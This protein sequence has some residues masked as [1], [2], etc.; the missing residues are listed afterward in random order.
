MNIQSTSTQIASWK[1]AIAFLL[2][3]LM[4]W[5]QGVLL[6]Q[7]VPAGST[8]TTVVPNGSGNGVPVVNIAAPN[9][10]GLS[11][12]Q[13]NSYSVPVQGQILNNSNAATAQTQLGGVILGNPNL[14]GRSPATIILNEVVQPNRSM[15]QGYQEVAGQS[16]QVIIANPY[17]I[18]CTGCGFINA[19]RATLTTGTPNIDAAGNLTGF[20]V[21][22]GDIL[23]NGAG[24]DATGQ[25]YFDLVARSVAVQGQV[26][27]KDLLVAAGGNDFS[28]AARS[29][30]P[31]TNTGAAPAYAIDSSAL[32]G[33][34]VDRIRLMATEAGVGVRLLGD[35][36]AS[37]DDIT[38]SSAGRIELQN[39]MSA[40]RDI[41]V[42][43]VGSATPGA[44]SVGGD[45]QIYANRNLGIAG[46]AGDIALGNALV[47]AGG[48]LGLTGAAL[49]DTGGASNYRFA[50]GTL[51]V[52]VAGAASL[53]AAT[54]DASGALL[55]SGASMDLG[56]SAIFG[57]SAASGISIAATG[58]SLA[59]SGSQLSSLG[60]IVLSGTTGVSV[61]TAGFVTS[62]ADVTVTYGGAQF[63]N[64]GAFVADG[65]LQITNTQASAHIRNFGTLSAAGSMTLGSG[66]LAQFTTEDGSSTLAA[67]LTVN[68]PRIV[69]SGYL[70]ADSANFV[71]GTDLSIG[72]TGVM[73]LGTAS[74]HANALTINALSNQGMLYSAG[75]LTLATAQISN[76][77]QIVADGALAAS[78]NRAPVGPL[79]NIITNTGAIDAKDLTLTA[80]TIDLTGGT[81]Y[82][83]NDASLM[84]T[85]TLTMGGSLYAA[86]DLTLDAATISDTAAG[87]TRGAGRNFT[88]TTA[89]DLNLGA[90]QV[91]DAGKK[92]AIT[93]PN[94]N[95]A[96]GASTADTTL[97]AGGTLA[98]EGIIINTGVLTLG[99][100]NAEGSLQ[101]AGDVTLAPR[102]S[103]LSVVVNGQPGNR[104]SIQAGG[105]LSSRADSFT[106][107]GDVLANGDINL[108]PVT[109]GG[110]SSL[111]V[112]DDGWMEAGGTLSLTAGQSGARGFNTTINAGGTLAGNNFDIYNGDLSIYGGAGNIGLLQGGT[113]GGNIDVDTLNL[114][115]AYSQLRAN[116]F[117]SG[118]PALTDIRINSTAAFNNFGLLYAEQ[119]LRLWVSGDI[120]NTALG[121]IA[122]GFGDLTLRARNL[123]PGV[124][125]R[126]DNEGLIYAGR[127]LI[128]YVPED[129]TLYNKP[130]ATIGAGRDAKLGIFFDA[131]N[132]PPAY[133]STFKNEGSIDVAG[134]A[135][136]NAS[137][138]QNNIPTTIVSDSTRIGEV[139][140]AEGDSGRYITF[141]DVN[142]TPGSHDG[143]TLTFGFESYH[144]SGNPNRLFQDFRIN[145]TEEDRFSNPAAVAPKIAAGGTLTIRTHTGENIGGDIYGGN[146][147]ILKL[148]PAASGSTFINQSLDLYSYAKYVQGRYVYYCNDVACVTNGEQSYLG[149]IYN[150]ASGDPLS[151]SQLS[152]QSSATPI[153]SKPASLR[154]AGVF[155]S[156][157]GSLS[158]V[159]GT[160]SVAP[161]FS[162]NPVAGSKDAQPV[163]GAPTQVAL[164]GPGALNLGGATITLPTG[165]NGQFIVSTNPNAGYLIES[166]PLFLSAYN[167]F[168]GS[169]YLAKQLGLNPAEQ[170]LRL[171]D[172]N[173]EARLIRE[174]ILAQTGAS[175]LRTAY[176]AY[177]QQKLLMDNASLEAKELKLNYGAALTA[178]QVAG[179]KHDIVWMVEQVV[180]GRRVLV[181]VV[182][183][184]SATRA[185]VSGAA[186]VADTAIVTGDSFLNRGGQV[187]AANRLVVV[188]RK[189]IV[190]SS[191]EIF[192]GNVQMQ[193]LEGDII[194]RTETFRTG[195]AANYTTSAG[196]SGGIYA[197]NSLFMKAGQDI[198]IE[199]AQV[200]SEGSATLVAGRNVNVSA[201]VLDSRTTAFADRSGVGNRDVSSVVETGQTA[202]N[203]SVSGATGTTI[204]A[205]QDVNLAGA[206]V[207]SKDGTTSLISEQGNVNIN[208]LQLTN[209]RTENIEHIGFFAESRAGANPQGQ[210]AA[211][212]QSQVAGPQNAGRAGKQDTVDSQVTR[213]TPKP[214]ADPNANTASA[215]TGLAIQT[216]NSSSSAT[217]NQGS[218]I[219]GGGVNIVAKSG[220][221]NITG[222]QVNSG[223]QGTFVDAAGNVNVMAAYDT[224]SS[225]RKAESTRVGVAAEAGPGGAYAGV[226]VDG[227][228]LDSQSASRTALTSGL[229]SQGSINIRAGGTLTNEG[230]SIDAKQNVNVQAAQVDNRAAQN[231]TSSTVRSSNFNVD[232]MGGVTTGG[233]GESIAGLAQ[234][235]SQEL[236]IASPEAQARLRASGGSSETTSSNSTAVVTEIKSGG[237]TN[238]QVSG[239][240]RDEGTAY[241]AGRNINLNVGSYENRQATNTSTSTT[242]S[243]SGGG[244]LT[245]GVDASRSVNANVAVQGRNEQSSTSSSTAEVGGLKA[246]GNVNITSRGDVTL[247]GTKVEAGKNVNVDATGN[248][249]L[250]QAVNTTRT[251]SRSS[252]GSANLS[253]SVCVDLSCASAG[254]G[255][256]ARTTTL[257]ETTSTGV[258][259]SLSGANVNLRSGGDMTLQG[260]NIAAQNDTTLSAGGNV[261]FQALTSTISS[262]S[263]ADGGGAN[264]SANVGASGKI[265]SDGG[266]G[267]GVNFERGRGSTEGTTRQGG[268]VTSGGTF[269]LNSGGNARL[270]G[271]NVN[272]GAANLNVAGN[273]TMES[274]QNTLVQDNSNVAG[275]VQV[276][277]GKSADGG[278][279]FGGSVSLDVTKQ[280]ADNLTNQNAGITTR[281]TTTLNV[282]GDATLAGANISAAGGVAGQVQ[283]NLTVETRA[284]REKT[285]DTS[286]RGYVGIGN[287][288]T[289][290]TGGGKPSTA[291]KIDAA[292]DKIGN[293]ANTAGGT[294]VFINLQSET[295]D[296]VTIGQQS[297]I[298][299]GSAGLGGLTVGGNA[300]LSGA[301]NT[302][303]I[304]VQGTTTTTSGPQTKQESSKTD[305]ALRGTVASMAGSDQ[306]S[307]G[308]FSNV[309]Q[310]SG[311]TSKPDATPDTPVTRPRSGAVSGDDARPTGLTR[312]QA[313]SAPVTLTRPTDNEPSGVFQPLQG[314]KPATVASTFTPTSRPR[315]DAVSGEGSRPSLAPGALP[316]GRDRSPSVGPESN[317]NAKPRPDF[318]PPTAIGPTPQ[319]S[320]FTPTPKPGPDLG[321]PSRARS[322]SMGT[323]TR[324]PAPTQD[325]VPSTTSGPSQAGVTFTPDP[326]TR[327]RSDVVSGEGARP[328]PSQGTPS[329]TSTTTSTPG[330]ALDLGGPSRARSESVG[331][332]TRK[333]APTQDFVP[334]T[335][336]GPSQAGTTFTPDAPL[337]TLGRDRSPSV[338]PESNP[339]AKPR[340]DFI[341]S[342]LSGPSQ[343]GVTFT[344]DGPLSTPGRDR[345][346]SVGPENNPNSKPVPTNYGALPPVHDKAAGSSAYSPFVRDR[347][348]WASFPARSETGATPKPAAPPPA[349]ADM[350][351]PPR[352]RS[353]SAPPLR[354]AASDTLVRPR[355][356]SEGTQAKP[357]T[358]RAEGKTRELT[359]VA[360]ANPR[361]A[362]D[363]AAP[364]P[365]LMSPD[366]KFKL[367]G[368]GDEYKGEDKGQG[369]R[370]KDGETVHYFNTRERAEA[371]V[372]IQ[373]GKFYTREFDGSGN[374]RR[375]DDGSPKLQALDTRGREDQQ[376]AIFVMDGNG[377]LYVT[378]K[379]E[380]GKVHH[381]SLLGG[382][383]VAMAGEIRVENGE[384]QTLNNM[385]GHYRPDLGQ[386]RQ[387]NEHLKSQN[388]DL[389]NVALEAATGLYRPEDKTHTGHQ[390]IVRLDIDSGKVSE[391][392]SENKWVVD[393]ERNEWVPATWTNPISGETSYVLTRGE[394]NAAGPTTPEGWKLSE[395][396]AIDDKKPAPAKPANREQFELTVNA[397]G[398]LVYKANPGKKFDTGEGRVLFVVDSEGKLYA[399]AASQSDPNFT[400]ASLVE[401]GQ[402]RLAGELQVKDGKLIHIDNKSAEYASSNQQVLDVLGGLQGTMKVDVSQTRGYELWENQAVDN[403]DG[404]QR[405]VFLQINPNTGVV[406]EIQDSGPPPFAHAAEPVAPSTGAPAPADG[407]RSAN[408]D[409]AR[410][411]A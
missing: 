154:A 137:I 326:T 115:G 88:I 87:A 211:A 168:L 179:L 276:S 234:G 313:G 325:F 10:A 218:F 114:S 79:V 35:V 72:A 187:Q 219:E 384:L 29:V 209:T 257:N 17:G 293:V 167:P 177:D 273:F 297:G 204:A 20:A 206:Y 359:V 58:G 53:G 66:S 309:F 249:N 80:P 126:I 61:A 98:G 102:T 39:R 188:T 222:S 100:T 298:S 108:R 161:T 370:W 366:G 411:A 28:Y 302:Q 407:A 192:A 371:E 376:G 36:G 6:A 390:V 56:T 227:G 339:N 320:T 310:A 391:V 51:T 367:K 47:G 260:T 290:G 18:T 145:W 16:A 133:L 170:M 149:A 85:G 287:I 205:K 112:N 63:T 37:V 46:G 143:R 296:N 203:A 169:D 41:A 213:A 368:L 223:A 229:G 377:K 4:I 221:V 327:S 40:Q 156:E 173:Y 392:I 210:D 246:G 11:H 99:G 295:K 400:H 239:A 105:N 408:D 253:A 201:L 330:P 96:T 228:S 150:D 360:A 185:N 261:D 176:D 364:K 27:A 65:N 194:N 118:A 26:N 410:R 109:N 292:Q 255:A 166:N 101:S 275:G 285:E 19:P 233:M 94:V 369:A 158:N 160:Q 142:F 280:T 183:L 175:I 303:G 129:G 308:T 162:P 299:G 182:Y 15:L 269:T 307:G 284:D 336:N 132:P 121:T 331:T 319:G 409:I 398:D 49:S 243:T 190:N 55:L 117:S 5:P 146:I 279:N 130:G 57:R 164:T 163:P 68:A 235:T 215:F 165:P 337:A 136:I 375:N 14:A 244:T 128:A 316:P 363:P 355:S 189:D 144:V 134:N 300:T 180:Q 277:A 171:G 403:G 306:G 8:N 396:I 54:Y 323:D 78:A 237:D 266:G 395:R 2:A 193:S 3:G 73:V 34:Y 352:A 226:K 50:D 24:L 231:T 329:P 271:T 383:A 69:S 140:T 89:S 259:G 148:D 107:D 361:P 321:A 43:Y 240:M 200:A 378:T 123:T 198:K 174:Q 81:I 281:G 358:P 84:A 272:A 76:Q 216:I 372:V 197:S 342:T 386:F 258:A 393:P 125:G 351:P 202:L 282:G 131:G 301:A 178:E 7:T 344:P 318:V 335:M 236:N 157:I 256:N 71:A 62:E 111:V 48:N 404:T 250:T 278:R 33:M 95:I 265:A 12:N 147:N 315:S 291:N 153:D 248:L 52:N 382:E 181:P 120:Y 381:S 214:P 254:A 59:V 317:P 25:N 401:S 312:P 122:S 151:P 127:D 104:S 103:S 341:P 245:V 362:G 405:S 334:P 191:G 304:N 357:A 13:F 345:S 116:R 220:D 141:D 1:R 314:G 110:A 155:L 93:A 397:V 119:N 373:G 340:P 75:D 263:T 349:S 230:T 152:Q 338:G 267:G 333:P 332:D 21:R 70:Q 30:T 402:V 262:R 264:L 9:A 387:M 91:Y 124:N 86:R 138:F 286:F 283:G 44:V 212:P 45:A 217:G 389:G 288:Q 60:S 67:T 241:D 305:F 289:S 348:G 42:N 139:W 380:K 38:L 242:N 23:I 90:G 184:T 31:A 32:G 324:K 385:S 208:T 224:A 399:N 135:D 388:V 247:Q 311:G 354:I 159:T 274:A 252:D 92:L 74:S 394:V 186:I 322:E 251:D 64:Q 232:L 328:M 77:G 82:A 365:G 195:D 374:A 356:A 294:G 106:V 270:E 199:G 172:A 350:L 343:A 353:D 207:G 22:M 225:T 196:R 97:S 268:T 113:V 406:V 379:Q 346:P 83:S 238:F 347:E